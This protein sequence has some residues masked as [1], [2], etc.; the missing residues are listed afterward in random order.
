MPIAGKRSLKD[1]AICLNRRDFSESSLV[2]VLLCRNTG[3]VSLL[4]K[5]ARRPTAAKA[6]LAVDLL[7]IGRVGFI[8]NP[9]GLGLLQEFA[10]LTG[11][12]SIRRDLDKWNA[13]LYLAELANLAAKDFAPAAELFDLLKHA[14][15]AIASAPAR[16]DIATLLV[17]AARAILAW[18]G[19]E[20]QL[21]QCV[22]CTRTL[23]PTDELFFSPS[24]G[25]LICRDCEPTTTDK[26][27]LEHRTWYYLLG[28][29]KD[30]ISAGKA[31]ELLDRM[32]YEHLGRSCRML[33]HCNDLFR[34]SEH[35]KGYKNVNQ[36]R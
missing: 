17:D 10:G 30:P 14:L 28:K 35:R 24:Q 25:G 22:F 3:K 9:D 23:K 15:D 8:M 27:R 11:F 12:G 1:E 36:D 18:S 19:F 26:L 20:P 7:D 31:F 6:S 29:V 5:G 4:A 13:C 33:R 21:R 32:T 34:R 16:E 2:L